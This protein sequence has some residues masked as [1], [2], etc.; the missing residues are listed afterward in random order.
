MNNEKEYKFLLKKITKNL[1]DLER[2]YR[3]RSYEIVDFVNQNSTYNYY[4]KDISLL[5]NPSK[6][7]FNSI[8]KRNKL[9]EFAEAVEKMVKS[10]EAEAEKKNYGKNELSVITAVNKGLD[11]VFSAHMAV[12]NLEESLAKLRETHD[13]NGSAYKRLSQSLCKRKELGWLLTNPGNPSQ[14]KI[15]DN[16]IIGLKPQ[17]AHVRSKQYW[18]LSW[19]NPEIQEYVYEYENEDDHTYILSRKSEYD[20]WQIETHYQARPTGKV[21]PK[22]FKPEIYSDLPLDK[23]H[24]IQKVEDLLGAGHIES[25]LEMVYAVGQ[26]L[27]SRDLLLNTTTLRGS[28]YSLMKQLNLNQISLNEYQSAKRVI[29]RELYQ[30][31]DDV[32]LEFTK[33]EA[34]I[35]ITSVA[36][37]RKE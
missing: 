18:L 13:E 16:S 15:I 29:A 37:E 8:G 3:C 6:Q 26:K 36:A 9:R 35:Q 1:L 23:S 5:K 25:G 34:L 4:Y 7:H 22:I 17:I 30:I 12:P 2:K 24:F 33:K 10:E 32:V 28:L 27:G 31:V 20:P 21:L 11:Y 14:Y 19:F